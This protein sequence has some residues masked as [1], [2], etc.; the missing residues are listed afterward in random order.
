MVPAHLPDQHLHRRRLPLLL[1]V[2]RELPPAGHPVCRRHLPGHRHDAL[3][4]RF[5]G[6]IRRPDLQKLP[7][8]LLARLGGVP[9]DHAWG[10]R[11]VS[12]TGKGWEGEVW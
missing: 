4:E 6:D 9:A 1:P 12:G 5:G 2:E 7:L 10:L 3:P 11:R 8:R